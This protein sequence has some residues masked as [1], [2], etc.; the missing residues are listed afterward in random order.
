[1]F[2]FATPIIKI[3]IKAFEEGQ[4]DKNNN[5][6]NNNNDSTPQTLTTQCLLAICGSVCKWGI[7]DLVYKAVP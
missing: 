4:G 2:K 6:N 3:K 1:M 5:N 7:H